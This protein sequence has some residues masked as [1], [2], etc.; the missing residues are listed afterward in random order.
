M[1]ERIRTRVTEILGIRYPILQA[2]MIWASGYKLAVACADHLR[3]PEEHVAVEVEGGRGHGR[4]LNADL[5]AFATKSV[6]KTGPDLLVR[7]RFSA[8]PDLRAQR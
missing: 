4:H 5:G 1:I 2:G 3:E 7:P 6:E 8:R